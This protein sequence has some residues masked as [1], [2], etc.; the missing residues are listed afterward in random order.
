MFTLHQSRPKG[1][2]GHLSFN[3]NCYFLSYKPELEAEI[4]RFRFRL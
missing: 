3:F 2:D 1:V 4:V